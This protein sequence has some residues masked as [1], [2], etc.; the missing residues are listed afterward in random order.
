MAHKSWGVPHAKFRP[1]K[2]SFQRRLVFDHVSA[3]VASVLGRFGAFVRRRAKQIIY[4][5]KGPSKPGKPPHSHTGI[6]ERFIYFDWDTR[7][8]SVVIG[9]A[10]TN[11]VFFDGDGLP[12]TGTV[13][14]VLEHGGSV[15]ILEA[16]NNFAGK[17]Y[18]ADLRSRRRLAE[19]KTRMRTVK[20]APRPY[21]SVA[22]EIEQ[23]NLPHMFHNAAAGIVT[24]AA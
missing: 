7:S 3:A 10:K 8:R 9:P 17:W 6:L 22:F 5:A 11:Q 23:R 18:R 24:R 19:K 16:F 20:I 1:G 21:M 2:F 12:V 13:P 4:K 15:R 14:S